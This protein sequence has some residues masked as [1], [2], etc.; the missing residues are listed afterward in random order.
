MLEV[1]GTGDFRVIQISRTGAIIDCGN[2]TKE[3]PWDELYTDYQYCL[4]GW[5]DPP[6]PCMKQKRHWVEIH[7][8]Q[9]PTQNEDPWN[10]Q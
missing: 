2:V 8:P 1:A 6:Q 5:S 7:R 3:I 4:H 9:P 10:G